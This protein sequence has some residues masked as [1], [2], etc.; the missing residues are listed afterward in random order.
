MKSSTEIANPVDLLLLGNAGERRC[1]VD[2]KAGEVTYSDMLSAMR[3]PMPR[4]TARIARRQCRT[5]RGL[6]VL[7]EVY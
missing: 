2:R 5:P 7:P 1:G 6:P 4:R 3:L